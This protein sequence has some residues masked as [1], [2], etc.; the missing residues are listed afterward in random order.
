MYTD[1]QNGKRRNTRNIFFLSFV[2]LFLAI[3]LSYWNDNIILIVDWR[4]RRVIVLRRAWLNGTMTSFRVV[5]E[6]RRGRRANNVVLFART[7]IFRDQSTN[8]E[9]NGT[10]DHEGDAQHFHCMTITFPW[11]AHCETIRRRRGWISTDGWRRIR[12]TTIEMKNINQLT[13]ADNQKEDGEDQHDDATWKTTLKKTI[14][15]AAYEFGSTTFD[16]VRT[17]RAD[18]WMHVEEMFCVRLD[19]FDEWE[20]IRE[21]EI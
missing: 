6:K 11:R 3:E 8:Q 20:M 10:R 4:R 2:L 7:R 13:R 19:G 18:H 21:L 9:R 15:I 1:M 5:C 14:T 16:G 12:I 17:E